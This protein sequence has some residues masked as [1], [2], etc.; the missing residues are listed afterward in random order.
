MNPNKNM[1]RETKHFF[2]IL[3]ARIVSV[4]YLFWFGVMCMHHHA[5]SMSIM[6]DIICVIIYFLLLMFLNFAIR[7]EE[8]FDFYA[9]RY[10]SATTVVTYLS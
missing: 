1:L 3:N 10:L 6:I 7:H 5:C 4:V 8:F 9:L 2:V